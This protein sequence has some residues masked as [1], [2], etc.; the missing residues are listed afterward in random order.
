M[1]Y[2]I[3]SNGSVIRQEPDSWADGRPDAISNTYYG[4]DELH[5]TS[6]S[7]RVAMKTRNAKARSL[8]KSGFTVKSDRLLDDIHFQPPQTVAFVVSGFK[9]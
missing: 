1:K 6:A 5:P 7:L 4:D 2:L 3:A 9:D 8:R